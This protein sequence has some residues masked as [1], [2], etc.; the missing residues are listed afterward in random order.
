MESQRN[1]G[2]KPL[3]LQ[4]KAGTIPVQSRDDFI[5]SATPKNFQ[6]YNL[7]TFN[8]LPKWLKNRLVSIKRLLD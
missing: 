8:I 5:A 6:K 3:P 1:S 2:A 4:C 7:L